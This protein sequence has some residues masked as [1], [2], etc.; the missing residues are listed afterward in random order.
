MQ[1]FVL[2]HTAAIVRITLSA[3][4][5][6]DGISLWLVDLLSPSLHAGTAL[7]RSFPFPLLECQLH[8]WNPSPTGPHLGR[9]CLCWWDSHMSDLGAGPEMLPGFPVSR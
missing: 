2:A 9:P 6:N 8:I 5:D 1:A 4:L 7:G 3:F